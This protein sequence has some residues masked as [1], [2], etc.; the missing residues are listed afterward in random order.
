MALAVTSAK[1]IIFGRTQL[2]QPRMH[3]PMFSFSPETL[4]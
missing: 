1:L 4:R 2:L 3:M